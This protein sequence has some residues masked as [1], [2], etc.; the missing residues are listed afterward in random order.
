MRMMLG[1]V[2]VLLGSGT[3]FGADPITYYLVDHPA[4]QEGWVLSG[5]I[6]TNGHIGDLTSESQILDWSWTAEHGSLGPVLYNREFLGN[7]ESEASSR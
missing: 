2:V 6:Q 3:S 1:V 5:W 4:D 7:V